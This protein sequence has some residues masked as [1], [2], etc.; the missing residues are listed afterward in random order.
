M[1]H[2][3]PTKIRLLFGALFLI[4]GCVGTDALDAPTIATESEQEVVSP[5]AKF[6]G[7]WTLADDQ[8]QQVWD[9]KTLQT[10]EIPNHITECG[11][12]N[13]QKSVLCVV[14]A[15]DLK[16][17]ILWAYDEGHHRVQH[18]SHFGE[19]RLGDGHGVKTASDDLKLEI[20]FTDEPENTYRL[21]EYTW[22]DEN[23][24]EMISTQMTD[25]GT[26]TGNWYG[27]VFVR[28]Q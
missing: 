9:T 11:P 23:T 22:I 10:I 24:Y 2:S 17:H 25:A 27:G 1:I 19:A 21:Y 16:G 28:V 12:I 20:R 6:F 13:T 4:A 5:F 18:L 8:F 3:K 7:T 26:P 15:G 14:D